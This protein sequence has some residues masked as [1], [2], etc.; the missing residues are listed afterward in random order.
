MKNE[1]QTLYD[2][3]YDKKH[4]KRERWEMHTVGI[5]ICREN[6]PTRKM[7]NSHGSTWNMAINTE[8]TAKWEKHGKKQWK[9]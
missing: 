9:T 6:W 3:E 8:K 1:K 2:P 5:G 4:W 7:R